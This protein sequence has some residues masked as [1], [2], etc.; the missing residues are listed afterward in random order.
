M[1]FICFFSWSSGTQQFSTS[2]TDPDLTWDLAHPPESPLFQSQQ[3]A[4]TKLDFAT[5]EVIVL[6]RLSCGSK[7]N[8]ISCLSWPDPQNLPDFI[9]S[10]FQENCQYTNEQQKLNDERPF[11]WETAPLCQASRNVK[12]V[13]KSSPLSLLLFSEYSYLS[14][15]SLCC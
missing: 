12:I 13:L 15:H 3:T 7:N 14:L 5:S 10:L 1:L 2:M 8:H 9:S 11:N 4:E 6:W